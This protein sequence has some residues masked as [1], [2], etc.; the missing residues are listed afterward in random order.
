MYCILSFSRG[1]DYSQNSLGLIAEDT[2]TMAFPNDIKVD[3]EGNIWILTDKF[4]ELV[5]SSIDRNLINMRI[6][7]AGVREAIKGTVCD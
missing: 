6:Y 5:Y 7:R 2:E 4:P 1:E 3:K